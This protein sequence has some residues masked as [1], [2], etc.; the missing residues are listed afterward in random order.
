M[1]TPRLYVV[2]NRGPSLWIP[3][4]AP[5]V[6][7]R[8]RAPDINPLRASP[9]PAD[10]GLAPL[11][12]EQVVQN[13][14]AI[15]FEPAMTHLSAL[16]A[17]VFHHS[18]DANYQLELAAELYKDPQ[19]L[20]RL[21][22]FV[23]SEPGMLVF[24]E[25]Y[26]TVLQ[27]LL[28]EHAAPT[29]AAERLTAQEGS[30]LLS[31]LLAIPG[32]VTSRAPDE[33]PTPGTDDE[34][35]DDWTAFVVQGG[36]YYEKPDLGDA[37]ARAYAVY[38]D[39]A[40][41]QEVAEHVDAC[42]LDEWMASDHQVGISEQLAT[43]FAAAIVS[44]AA[45][46]DLGL[47]GR[48]VALEPGW[49]GAG[50]LGEREDQLTTGLAA[51]RN[52]LRDAFANAGTTAEHVSWDRAP[53]EQRP[54]LRLEDGRLFL[55]SPRAIFSWSTAGIYYR[56]L[57][58]A[59]ARPNPATPGETL[60]PKFTRFV[61][62]LSEEYVV[63]LT[64]EALSVEA[65]GGTHVRGDVEYVV[66][67]APKRSPDVAIQEGQDLILVEVFSGR[68]PRLARVLADERRM[69]EALEKVLIEKLEQLSKATTD[70]LSGF[71]PFPN[72]D[73]SSVKRVW[74]VLVLP[75]GG[76]VQLPVLW[77]YI[78]RHLGEG[79]FLDE[80][81]ASTTIAT[82]D[83]YEP[84]LAVAEDERMALSALLAE[85]HASPYNELPPRNWVRVTYPREGASRPQWVQRHYWAA[86]DDMKRALGIKPLENV[87]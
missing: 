11:L 46:V 57:D 33:P 52:E 87:E 6:Q 73:I 3:T 84:L 21:R 18:D 63:R 30:I 83:D 79:A 4:S 70:V 35:L 55:T 9:D 26:I 20:T 5:G 17:E 2:R 27:R 24:D 7:G 47:S 78:E 61:G 15:P 39:L 54:F 31:S 64:R 34:Q 29:A 25:R 14:T 58:S 22:W 81:I 53:F 60:L 8:N 50:I 12:F 10:L 40:R 68:L 41:G 76:I 44:K 1:V 36:A 38:C 72:I 32:I 13:L 71:V 66:D 43:G 67:G 19:L 23:E 62:K 56:L 16:A 48:M 75:A 59:K 45:E 37:L 65:E 69:S 28:V 42:P 77:R 49:L 85:Y 86:A 82:L 80:R 51:T 74:P